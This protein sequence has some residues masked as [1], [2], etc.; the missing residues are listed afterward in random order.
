MYSVFTIRKLLSPSME[1][2]V[3]LEW[4][5][6]SPTKPFLLTQDPRQWGYRSLHSLFLKEYTPWLQCIFTRFWL[7]N[8][9]QRYSFIGYISLKVCLLLD[10]NETLSDFTNVVVFIW[11]RYM[12]DMPLHPVEVLLLLPHTVHWMSVPTPESGI[13]FMWTKFRH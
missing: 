11:G 9:L 3:F 13:W 1:N 6:Y 2:Q 10:H 12:T 5:D 8:R 4:T 7:F